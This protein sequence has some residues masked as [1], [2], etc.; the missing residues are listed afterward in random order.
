MHAEYIM[1]VVNNLSYVYHVEDYAIWP[2]VY[3]LYRMFENGPNIVC[4][5]GT[6]LPQLILRTLYNENFVQ[7]NRPK[8]LSFECLINNNTLPFMLHV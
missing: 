6:E 5:V 8:L 2:K 4:L 3:W 7:Y 1:Y